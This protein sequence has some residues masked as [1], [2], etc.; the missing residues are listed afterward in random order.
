MF[1]GSIN[2]SISISWFLAVNM[3]KPRTK[4]QT[5]NCRQSNSETIVTSN[6]HQHRLFHLTLSFTGT[7]L[8]I[9]YAEMVVYFILEC[10][11]HLSTE[12]QTKSSFYMPLISFSLSPRIFSHV[13]SDH[14]TMWTLTPAMWCQ[15]GRNIF[16]IHDLNIF[17]AI[18]RWVKYA[19]CKRTQLGVNTYLL[20]L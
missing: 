3:I 18:A 15:L 4:H 10:T 8:L 5:D 20:T 16:P 1:L 17:A 12:L 11:T 19:Q 6:L 14:V 7:C 9:L 13:P 2:L